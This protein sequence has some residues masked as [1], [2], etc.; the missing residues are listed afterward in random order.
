MNVYLNKAQLQER[1]LRL[2]E[3]LRER[4]LPPETEHLIRQD[5]REVERYLMLLEQNEASN[6]PSLSL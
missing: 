3:L 1:R 5:L 4:Q 6:P 2:A